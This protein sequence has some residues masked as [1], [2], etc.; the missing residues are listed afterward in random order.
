MAGLR[1]NAL[2][3]Q[4]R[5]CAAL[6][7]LS[8]AVHLLAAGTVAHGPLLT[9]AM[10]LMAV[11]CVPCALSLW[12]SPGCTAAFRLLGMSLGMLAAHWVLVFGFRGSLDGHHDSAVMAGTPDASSGMGIM[13][14]LAMML[15][16]LGIALAVALWLRRRRSAFAC[17]ANAGGT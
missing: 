15:M 3:A 10:V 16:E 6:G 8:A 14:M 7:G 4:R 17:A 5:L 2:D 11:L 13:V 12:R 9:A 1:A